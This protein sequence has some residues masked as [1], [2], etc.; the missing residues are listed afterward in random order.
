ME[1]IMRTVL[2]A[3]L[4]AFTMLISK[5]EGQLVENFYSSSCPNVESMVKQA[6]TNKFTETITTGQATLR[7]FF[8]DCFVEGCDASVI[9]SSPNGD[10]EK[11]A[12]EN[13]SLPGDGFDTVIKAKQAV[14]ASCPGVVSC[15]DILALATRDV[16][17]LLGGP[18]FNVE[19]GRRDGLISKA[20]SV[21]GNL[22]KANFNL[23]QLNALFAKHGLTQT[24]VIALSG[25]H[26]VGFSHCDQFANRLYS[27]SSSNPV[28]PTLDPTYA[29]DLMAGCP[30]NPDPAVVLP[31]DPQSPAAFDNAYY[32]NLLSG[33]G[34]LTSDQVLFEDATSQPTVV[35]FANSAADFNDAFVAAMRKLGRVGVKTG[36]DGEIRRDC[37]TFNS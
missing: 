16:I 21:E 36:K 30:R 1:K 22:P 14:E 7:L 27:F 32:Q 6:V 37:T 20:S 4:M 9:I 3:L 19:L 23:D 10:T 18:S 25:A 34:L 11:D 31:L 33:K 28:D 13:I 2:M 5:G 17:G 8:H 24:D 29:Q 15:A 26:T 35:R 12:E